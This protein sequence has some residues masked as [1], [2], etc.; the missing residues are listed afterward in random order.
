MALRINPGIDARTH[1]K[2]STGKSENK[3]GI[4]W[5]RARAVYGEAARL[6]GLEIVGVDVHIG[7]QI[8]ALEP[9]VSAFAALRDLVTELRADGHAISRLDLGGGLGVPYESEAPLPPHPD[10]YGRVI[11]QVVGDLD[12]QL[13]TEPGRLIVGNAGILVARV[14][15]AK[16]GEG[17]R[18]LIIDAGMNDLIRP[19]LYDAFHEIIPVR[20]APKE[21][22]RA[23]VDVVGP[24]CESADLFARDRL[25]PALEPGA[26]V[27]ILTAGA[28]GAV[29][30]STYNTRPL[31]PEILV[32]GADWAVVRP[33]FDLDEI[34]AL[35][36]LP[37]WLTRP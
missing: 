28:Y 35:D 7:S 3:F 1:A 9:F 14:V 33:R 25:L 17:R 22:K 11:R 30:A 26:L 16:E 12:L 31:V 5:R 13:V 21:A 37:P 23:P 27:A 36:K 2:I 20:E 6:P 19:A 15:Y 34:I 8:T 32:R 10:E 29:Q 24:V 18:F 4:P